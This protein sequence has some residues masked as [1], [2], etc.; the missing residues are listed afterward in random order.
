MP[1]SGTGASAFFKS[2]DGSYQGVWGFTRG[3]WFVEVYA[4]YGEGGEAEVSAAVNG[5]FAANKAP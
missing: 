1:G 5:L 2:D 4:L 3:D